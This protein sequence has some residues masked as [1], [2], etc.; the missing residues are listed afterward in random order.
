M[1]TAA[2]Y[3]E[4]AVLER[5]G[6]IESRHFGSLVALNSGGTAAIELGEPDAAMLPR[7]TVKPLQ[8]V[9]FLTAGAPLTGE[10]LALATA[11]HTGEDEHAEGARSILRSAGLDVE[12]L[13]CPADRPSDRATHERLV[14]A[15]EPRSAIRMNCSGKHA[16]MLLTCA[17]NGWSTAD[18]LSLEHPLQLHI[19]A[20]VTEYTGVAVEH[21]AIDGCGAPLF[22][23]TVRGI[24]TA[25]RRLVLADEREPAGLV[26]AA[27]RAH[28]F[29]VGGTGN[30]NTRLM[31]LLPG[32]LAKGG[33]EGVIG[34]ATAD[35]SAV[36][37]KVID[38]NPRATTLVALHAL[39]TL[40]YD[41]GAAQELLKLPVY[42]GSDI[43]GSI[44][45][46]CDLPGGV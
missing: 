6:F 30:P 38:G 19:R 31:Q 33:A 3:A 43:V 40:G 13:Q 37:M 27:M 1:T 5:S 16:A 42:G 8:G 7:S 36:S 28:P 10:L 20:T 12:A 39:A 17:V 11:S 22:S 2:S 25:F 45:P 34:V 32:T 15:G 35:G 26:A 21:A 24:A 46:G 23:T 41:V 29:S 9:A 14:A 44:R 4:L 18:Y